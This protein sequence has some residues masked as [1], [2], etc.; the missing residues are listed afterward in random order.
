MFGPAATL[1]GGDGPEDGQI[2]HLLLT[3]PSF[4][5]AGGTDE[6]QRNVIGERG[7]GLP[8]EPS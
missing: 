7:L 6:I 1:T 5:I 4:S 2:A 3:T 8:R